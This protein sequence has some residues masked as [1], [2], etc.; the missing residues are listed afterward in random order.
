MARIA[1]DT[2]SFCDRDRTEFEPIPVIG[3]ALT[4]N[5]DVL[6]HTV[7]LYA[8]DRVMHQTPL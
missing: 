2:L 3:L 1:G 5:V 6:F 4:V 7:D 8:G